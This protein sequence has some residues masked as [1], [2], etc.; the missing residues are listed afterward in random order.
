MDEELAAW[1][2]RWIRPEDRLRGVGPLFRNPDGYT[3]DKRW[4]PSAM[5]RTW[6]RACRQVGVEV[7]LWDDQRDLSRHGA[8][9]LSLL[10]DRWRTV[11][12]ST[13]NSDG[14]LETRATH[15]YYVAEWQV[16]GEPVHA[17]FQ[18]R[19]GAGALTVVLARP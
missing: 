12:I 18:V 14:W 8:A 15:G 5:R 6:K 17:R 3:P 19:P 16:D 13:T 10:N 4:L 9:V 7:G 2:E 11:L 1:F